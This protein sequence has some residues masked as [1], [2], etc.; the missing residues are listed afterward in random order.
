MIT[1]QPR[2]QTNCNH[3]LL[4]SLIVIL[5]PIVYKNLSYAN[6]VSTEQLF[7]VCELCWKKSLKKTEL[8]S[9]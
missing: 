7:G 1:L 2:K 3:L 6:F 9:E 8:V 4:C 5:T